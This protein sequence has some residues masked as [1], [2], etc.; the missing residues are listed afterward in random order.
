VSECD[1]ETSKSGGPGSLGTV[2]PQ[3]YTVTAFNIN[4]MVNKVNV[5]AVRLT[6]PW[7]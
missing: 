1:C 5:F 6:S 7:L 3:K 2:V 4:A